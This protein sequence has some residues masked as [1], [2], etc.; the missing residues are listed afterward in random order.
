[1]S[2]V[3]DLLHDLVRFR[4]LSLEEGRIADYVEAYARNAELPVLRHADNVCFWIGDGPDVLLLN[5]HLDVVPPSADHPFDPFDPVIKDGKLYGRGSVDAKASGASMTRALIELGEGGWSP[6]GGKVMVALTACE[7]GGGGYNGLRDLRSH[8]PP[9]RAALIGEPTDMQPCIAQRGILILKC[10]A[11]GRTAHAARAHL[12]DNAI[13]RAARD[14]TTLSGL[15][16]DRVDPFLGA[17]SLN[18]TVIDGGTK[19]NVI[20]DRCTF[21]AD[22]R[23][24]PAY[25]HAELVALV[26]DAI[27]SEVEVH[28][29]RFISVSTDP[30]ERILAACR[31]ALPDAEPFGSPTASDWVMIHGVPTV[32]IGPGFSERSHTADEHIDVATVE[33]AVEG[34]KAIIRAYFE[35]VPAQP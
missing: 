28:S 6:P 24:T 19:H 32:K 11:H 35:C 29:D 9:L 10:H 8:L 14:I 17:I 15:T 16:F 3:I 2:P 25:S 12:G 1:M 5:S 33:Q 31:S 4:S 26:R 23:S 30:G 18:V 27:E 34:Y 22:I 13:V 20:P 21:T 7:E